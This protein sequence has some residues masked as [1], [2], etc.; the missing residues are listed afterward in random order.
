MLPPAVK[1]TLMSAQGPDNRYLL[2]R[3]REPKLFENVRLYLAYL[4]RQPDSACIDGKT[5]TNVELSLLQEG[6]PT[7]VSALRA[8]FIRFSEC[9]GKSQEQVRL[10]LETYASHISSKHISSLNRF[11]NDYKNYF[12]S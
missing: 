8:I 11:R 12:R 10:D 2:S 4:H 1:L 6:L 9:Y 5:K 3:L 7:D